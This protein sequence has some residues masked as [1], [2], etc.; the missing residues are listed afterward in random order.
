MGRSLLA[1]IVHCMLQVNHNS[2]LLS[3][4][5]HFFANHFFKNHKDDQKIWKPSL[6]QKSKLEIKTFDK[7]ILPMDLRTITLSK[8]IYGIFLLLASQTPRPVGGPGSGWGRNKELRGT[9][10][11]LGDKRME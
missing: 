11:V 9:S 7:V 4:V 1:A 3:G 5:T 6:C 2:S 8:T 10:E